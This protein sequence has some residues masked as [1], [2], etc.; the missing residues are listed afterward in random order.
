[1]TKDK[2]L[3]SINITEI[4][5]KFK[6]EAANILWGFLRHYEFSVTETGEFIDTISGVQMKL[7]HIHCLLRKDY[8]NAGHTEYNTADLNYLIESILRGAS[9]AT[10]QTIA[11]LK[12]MPDNAALLAAERIEAHDY[13]FI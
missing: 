3:F 11:R 12:E 13:G 9:L 6:H 1:M 7:N 2:K 10:V 5:C 4:P 8:A